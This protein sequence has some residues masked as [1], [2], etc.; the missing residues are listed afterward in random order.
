[1]D[2]LNSSKSEL[3]P[4]N[5]ERDYRNSGSTKWTSAFKTEDLPSNKRTTR[6]RAYSQD[7]SIGIN[8]LLDR[9]STHYPLVAK[10]TPLLPGGNPIDR[11]NNLIIRKISSASEYVSVTLSRF[12]VG[13]DVRK[14][15]KLHKNSCKKRTGLAFELLQTER[16]YVKLIG[17]IL[18]VIVEPLK[19]RSSDPEPLMVLQDIKSIF[20]D[21]D[22]I[23]GI[24]SEF[25]RT[26]EPKITNW[27]PFSTV[28]GDIFVSPIFD[29]FRVYADYL[30]SYQNSNNYLK[31]LI[32]TNTRL[33]KFLLQAEKNPACEMQDLMMLM[34]LPIQR[35][36]RYLLYVSQ[37][38]K[39]T[40]PTH[41]DYDNLCKAKKNLEDMNKFLNEKMSQ[42]QNVRRLVDIQINLS[43]IEKPSIAIESRVFIT[44]ILLSEVESNVDYN[45]YLFN[46][47]VLIT[48][49]EDKEY[50][51][52]QFCSID[53]CDIFIRMK[54][55]KTITLITQTL[56]YL[57]KGEDL[58]KL[59]EFFKLFVETK[60]KF[61]KQI[62][63]R[64][65]IHKPFNIHASSVKLKVPGR[66]QK[67]FSVGSSAKLPRS[68]RSSRLSKIEKGNGYSQEKYR[69]KSPF[70]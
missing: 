55:E 4:I 56:I 2:S 9:L 44:E 27:D 15:Y 70:I 17:A 39:Y 25:L 42:N 29:L 21:L 66:F 69:S 63:S 37:I 18:T 52:Q 3:I 53:T 59:E 24:N 14:N 60:G 40:W 43:G 23:F 41:V 45:I 54:E 30:K 51:L 49:A 8:R 47:S 19:K 6:P 32:K 46:D 35:V 31:N 10:L 28:L 16:R 67:M 50:R 58:V 68:T 7:T 57:L 34:L 22:I 64:H 65:R 20:G 61:K 36:P 1:M 38:L 13:F 12:I 26:L 33:S 5:S 11:T 62:E 48:I